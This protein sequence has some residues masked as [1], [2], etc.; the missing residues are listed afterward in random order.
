MTEA[1]WLAA[2][3]P[4]TMLAFLQGKASERKLRLLACALI[5]SALFALDG[6]SMWE[7]APGYKWFEERAWRYE[8]GPDGELIQTNEL[9]EVTCHEAI[10]VAERFADA[11]DTALL[12]ATAARATGFARYDAEADTFGYNTATK[13]GAE[14]RYQIA[15][16]FQCATGPADGLARWMIPPLEY[17]DQPISPNYLPTAALL[18]RDAFG[19]PFRPVALD[20]SWRTEAVV[21]LAEG[22]YAERAFE[23]MPVL[24][25]ALED[26]GCAHADILS[27]CRGDGP[28]VRGCWVVDLLTG[29]T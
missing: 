3:D 18:V 25:D 2:T 5:R 27:H 7:L 8:F 21:A 20:P 16:C 23:R 29:R 22:I 9:I 24:A 4:R 11:P 17:L 10:E 14:Y 28:H 6:R 26:A 19:N 12:L 1:E 15:G 13:P